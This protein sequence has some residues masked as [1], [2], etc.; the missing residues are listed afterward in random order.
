MEQESE[1]EGELDFCLQKKKNCGA[2]KNLICDPYL[3]F[4]TL[5]RKCK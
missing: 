2:I 1:A 3:N 5:M 4:P